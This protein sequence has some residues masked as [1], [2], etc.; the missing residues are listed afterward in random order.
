GACAWAF[1]G[2]AGSKSRVRQRPPDFFLPVA[3]SLSQ[4]QHDPSAG[5]LFGDRPDFVPPR[6]LLADEIHLY[7]HVQGAQIGYTLR[8]LLARC[9]LNARPG[10]PRPARPLAVG[11]S[12]TLG[13]PS[14]V[15]GQLTGR[16]DVPE[17]TPCRGPGPNRESAE[18]RE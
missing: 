15:W 16:G 6:A 7:S 4:W 5:A 12:A 11:M 3:E 18:L 1:D 10:D 9:E 2:W 14:A 13:E 8:R 17:I